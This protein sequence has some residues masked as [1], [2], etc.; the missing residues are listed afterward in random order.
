MLIDN[1]KEPTYEQIR[2]N[3]KVAEDDL[4]IAYACWYPQMGGYLGKCVMILS[5]QPNT[6]FEAL[7]WHDGE[8]PFSN[9]YDHHSQP[10]RIHHCDAR[11]FIEFGTIVFKLQREF[12]P[13]DEAHEDED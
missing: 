7:V 3:A 4:K 1:I 11:Q 6:C 2:D 9:G 12:D 13:N 8:F 10:V 5:K